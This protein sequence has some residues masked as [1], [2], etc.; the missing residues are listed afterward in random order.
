MGKVQK[1][2]MATCFLKP[3]VNVLLKL[4][5]Y[6]RYKTQAMIRQSAPER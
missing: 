4:R 2:A 5:N 3:K 6:Q 1:K